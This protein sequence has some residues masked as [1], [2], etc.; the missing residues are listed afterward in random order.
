MTDLKCVACFDGLSPIAKPIAKEVVQVAYGVDLLNCLF[1]IILHAPKTDEIVLDHGV[2]RAGVAI[3][4]LPYGTY[5]DHHLLSSKAKL[6]ADLVRAE[7][8]T[9]LSEDA[10]HM[11]VPLED[12]SRHEREDLL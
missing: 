12:V 11:S 5:I 6:V 10:G 2:A 9:V 7:E 1:P 3:T 4:G 8:I